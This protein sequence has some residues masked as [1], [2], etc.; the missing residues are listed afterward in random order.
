MRSVTEHIPGTSAEAAQRERSARNLIG[1]PVPPIDERHVVALDQIWSI[2][3]HLDVRHLPAPALNQICALTEL[4]TDMGRV[5]NVDRAS[6]RSRHLRR[7]HIGA[8]TIG[9]DDGGAIDAG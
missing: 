5:V 6:F 9:G 8:P 3:S 2:L 4:V 1:V 7:S